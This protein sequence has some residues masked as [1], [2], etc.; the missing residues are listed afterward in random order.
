MA[1]FDRVQRRVVAGPGKRDFI[2]RGD[3]R[4]AGKVDEQRL[5]MRRH[6]QSAKAVPAEAVQKLEIVRRRVKAG[7]GGIHIIGEVL[8]KA[9]D[10]Q[11][12]A[13]FKQFNAQTPPP[14]LR[15]QTAASSWTDRL[16]NFGRL[17][18]GSISYPVLVCDRMN[19]P[20]SER[21]TDCA[22]LLNDWQAAALNLHYCRLDSWRG[23]RR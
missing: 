19:V 3:R 16:V 1:K 8:D 18:H 12:P 9:A 13:V 22:D 6:V 2:D 17:P 23:P 4:V 14:R 21:A 5:R 11:Q 10:R 15:I 7:H 20:A